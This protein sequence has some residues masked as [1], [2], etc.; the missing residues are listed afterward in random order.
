M[1]NKC[2][3]IT[4]LI[5]GLSNPLVVNVL[6]SIGS[7]LIFLASYNF[8][9]NIDTIYC[10]GNN[11]QKN[12]SIPV[13]RIQNIVYLFTVLICPTLLMAFCFNLK[14]LKHD[15]EL[16]N[17]L[18]SNNNNFRDLITKKN[19]KYIAK[20]SCPATVGIIP[21]AVCVFN[22]DNANS[23]DILIF[24]LGFI[25]KHTFQN[26]FLYKKL[27]SRVPTPT[28]VINHHNRLMINT[29]AATPAPSQTLNA[30][31]TRS[32]HI[33]TVSHQM[34]PQE[35]Q[36]PIYNLTN[37]QNYNDTHFTQTST[38][39][40]INQLYRNQLTSPLYEI[41]NT[42]NITD[43]PNPLL[44]SSPSVLINL[45]NLGTTTQASTENFED[46][47][48][49]RSQNPEQIQSPRNSILTTSPSSTT[50]EQSQSNRPSTPRSRS[51]NQLARH[52]SIRGLNAIV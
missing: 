40:P 5:K 50:P 24:S 7:G 37:E 34:L 16:S 41:N 23:E 3:S 38:E 27:S 47:G 8:F 21:A 28:A 42:V 46:F 29:I 49:L 19:L 14:L 39:N 31:T 20:I 4:T 48:N 30:I 2:E 26:H 13:D 25:A 32:P 6:S 18:V 44:S 15:E 11:C 1:R 51:F 52:D 36:Q 33:L 12:L 22:Q 17:I 43:S 10:D 9:K 45:P 35:I